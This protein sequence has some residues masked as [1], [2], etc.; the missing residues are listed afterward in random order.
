MVETRGL[1]APF[2][3]PVNQKIEAIARSHGETL[4]D[5]VATQLTRDDIRDD[6]LFL[7]ID[8]MTKIRMLKKHEGIY[9]IYSLGEFLDESALEIPS[10]YGADLAAYSECYDL[11]EETMGRVA[12]K[13]DLLTGDDAEGGDEL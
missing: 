2:P 5:H 10:P 7:T 6:T 3:E 8:L 9:H 4:E 13:I 12:L 11:I 1:V